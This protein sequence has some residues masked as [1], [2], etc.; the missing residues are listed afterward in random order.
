L[1]YGVPNL[2]GWK[3]PERLNTAPEKPNLIKTKNLNFGLL[4]QV[5]R[6]KEVPNHS[7]WK[8]PERLNKK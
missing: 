6:H 3:K 5:F 7:G 8:K 1:A 2:S 4:F